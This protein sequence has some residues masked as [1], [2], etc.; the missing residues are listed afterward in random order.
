M[1]LPIKPRY[2]SWLIFLCFLLF[3]FKRSVELPV[4]IMAI[5]GMVLT[6]RQ[7]KEFL[8]LP[9]IRAFSLLTA[10]IW[11]PM[12]LSLPDS[13]SFKDTGGAVLAFVRLYFA[14]LF[15]IWALKDAERVTLLAKLLAALTAFWVGDALIQAAVGHDLFGYAQIP[16]RLNGVFGERHWRLGVALPVLAPF[17]IIS[18]RHRPGLMAFALLASGAVVLMAGSRGGWVSFAVVCAGLIW[19]EV[20]RRGISLW[21]TALFATLLVVLGG[22][23]AWENPGTRARLDQSLLLFSGD[24]AKIDAALSYRWTLWKDAAGMIKAHSVNGVGVR[25]FSFAYPDFAMPGDPF[26]Q[27]KLDEESGK[28]TGASYAHQ[29]VLEVSTETGLIGLAGL[30]AFYFLLIRHWRQ[31]DAE[32]KSRSLPFALAALAWLFPLNTHSSFYSAQWS[33]LVWLV[34]AMLCATLLSSDER[35]EASPL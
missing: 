15:V 10:C 18:V 33:V 31:A 24:E 1:S 6:Y 34:V 16:S 32:Q 5:G 29:M 7:G 13:Y 4:V 2:S 9:A 27:A 11:I 12:L 25:A 21:K 22:F 26:I 8:G 35:I 3:P 20:R 14:G 17:L 28:V 30:A 23:L 19:S